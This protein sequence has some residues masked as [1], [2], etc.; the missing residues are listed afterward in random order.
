MQAVG[1]G[2]QL[3]A[4][5]SAEAHVEVVVSRPGAA[6]ETVGQLQIEVGTAGIIRDQGVG[7][8]PV[9]QVGAAK[10]PRRAR[11]AGIKG[12]VQETCGVAAPGIEVRMGE[13]MR[14]R[15]IIIA[16][17]EAP[18]RRPSLPTSP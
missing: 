13:R 2:L 16:I 11:V 1:F 3:P 6:R 18:V 12:G 8:V 7:E 10:R 9:I 15:R 4:L 5:L 14:W 17:C